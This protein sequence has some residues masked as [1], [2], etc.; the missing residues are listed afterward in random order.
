MPEELAH[1]VVAADLEFPEG[2]VALGDGSVLVVEIRGARL[3]RIRPD[4][5]RN[6]VASWAAAVKWRLANW[7]DLGCSSILD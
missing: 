4:G 3:T 2:P 6:T 1:D 5:S 7:H